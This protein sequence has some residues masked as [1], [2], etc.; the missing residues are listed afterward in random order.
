MNIQPL[1]DKWL[2]TWK[3]PS[4]L[5]LSN[6]Q[7]WLYDIWHNDWGTLSVIDLNSDH[8]R[9]VLLKFHRLDHANWFMLRW[10]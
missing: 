5:E 8:L 6:A 9:T 4:I 7:D 10:S 2:V 1:N 3:K